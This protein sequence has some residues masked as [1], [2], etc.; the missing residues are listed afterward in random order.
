MLYRNP[1]PGHRF[2]DDEIAT[3]TLLEQMAAWVRGDGPPPYPL[4]EGDPGPP[5]RAG[6]R[7]GG[8]HRHHGDHVHRGLDYDSSQ[9]MTKITGTESSV[10][11]KIVSRAKITPR[12]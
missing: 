12:S 5:G 9:V 3:A 10:A 6:R 4:A 1:Y 11:T 8:R 2:N 7:A